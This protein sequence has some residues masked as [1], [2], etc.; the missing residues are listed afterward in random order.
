MSYHRDKD[1]DSAIIHL[2]DA[3]CQ[4]ERNSGRRS[5]L[6]FIPHVRDEKIILAQDGK[7]I[8]QSSFITPEKILELAMRERNEE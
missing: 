5:T 4:F 1:V 7:P 3:L 8:L 2:L 6:I